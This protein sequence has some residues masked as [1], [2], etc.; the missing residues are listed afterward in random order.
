MEKSK[1]N[2]QTYLGEEYNFSLPLLDANIE[3]CFEYP[4]NSNQ[5][6]QTSNDN[7]IINLNMRFYNFTTNPVNINSFGLNFNAILL[8][9][10]LINQNLVQRKLKVRKS[11]FCI[12]FVH[13]NLICIF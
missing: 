5:I 10:I 8:E 9:S 11:Y 4:N 13:K 1:E 12:N 6:N 2:F 3:S 7:T